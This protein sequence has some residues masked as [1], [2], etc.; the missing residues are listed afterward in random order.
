MT[1]V[2]EHSVAQ[3]RRLQ[4]QR[5]RDEAKRLLTRGTW[6]EAD[7]PR[8]PAGSEDGGQFT[9]GGGGGGSS[10]PD[11]G[12]GKKASKGDFTKAKIKINVVASEEQAFIDKWNAKIGIEPEEFKKQFAGGVAG[13]MTISQSGSAFEIGGTVESGGR[14]VGTFT[15][16]INVDDHKA[17]S[18]YF[19]LDRA[20]TK[21]NIAKKIL[22]GNVETYQQLGITEVG[23]TANIDVGGYA[24]A[25]YG[26]V[27]TQGAW[28]SLRAGLERK[29]TGGGSSGRTQREGTVEA[30]EWDALSSDTQSDVRDRWMRDSYDEFYTNEVDNWRDNGQA[31]ADEKSNLAYNFSDD[32]SIPDWANDAIEAT[33]SDRAATDHPPIPYTNEQLFAAIELEYESDYGDGR[34]NPTITFDDDMLREPQGVDPNQ[35]DLPGIDAADQSKRLTKAMRDELETDL[36]NA[37][38]DKAKEDAENAEPP[39]YLNESVREYQDQYWDEKEDR[40]KLQLAIDYGMAD[41]EVDPDEDED[42]DVSADDGLG[43]NPDL[44]PPDKDPLL[45]AVQST[46]PKSIWK[47]ADHAR[48]KELLLG[49]NW[50]G[51]LYLNDAAALKRFKDYVSRG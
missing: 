49:T 1:N 43:L 25:K 35:P 12:K 8:E 15:R 41:I 3:Q 28:N 19:K 27:P 16:N 2:A 38:N 37:F 30:D 47:I 51:K 14:T 7:H 34:E 20:A 33:R 45:E 29:L 48:G 17:Y 26:Y 44:F 31:L 5:T 24:W 22:G 21:G 11:K 36:I 39:E 9:S 50:S 6:N 4:W 13:D 18:A 10:K 46:D 23:V 40:E 42:D 32:S